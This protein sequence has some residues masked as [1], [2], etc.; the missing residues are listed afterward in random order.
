LCAPPV[1]AA[2]NGRSDDA[3]IVLRMPSRPAALTWSD[4]LPSAS[5]LNRNEG[6]PNFKQP[7]DDKP[8]KSSKRCTPPAPTASTTARASCDYP[9]SS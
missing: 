8:D 4:D 7:L 3:R 2:H 1:G 6:Q 5:R 9:A